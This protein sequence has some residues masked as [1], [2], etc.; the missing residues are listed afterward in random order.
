MKMTAV[1]AG[2]TPQTRPMPASP[3]TA[4]RLFSLDWLRI[5]LTILV[6]VH[7]IGQAYGPTGGY[8]PVQEPTRAAILGP[9]F[10]VNRSFF[11]SLFFLISGYF[12]VGAYQRNGF[13][14][15]LRNRAVRLGVP[16][17]VFAVLMIPARI[18]LFGEH[19]TRW[20]NWLNAGHLWYLEH[21][22]L[23][24]VVYA[25]WQKIRAARG[26]VPPG[27]DTRRPA[28]G[29]LVTLPVLVL[30]AAACGIV[31]IWSP[32]DRWMNLLGF[33]SVAF[34]DVPRDLAF[35]IFGA[36]AFR[37]GWLESF[38]ARRG[39]IW[40]GIGLA[41]AAAWY[42]WS[43]IPHAHLSPMAS[44]LVYVIWEELVCF[45]MCIGLLVLFRQAA[46]VQG[47]FGRTL[48]ANQY[49]AYFWHPILIVGI[50]MA[51]APLPLGPLVK[52]MAVTVIG[53]PVVFLWSWLLRRARAVRAVL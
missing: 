39:M 7:H 31:R 42:A 17:L 27:Q 28:P 37:R 24:S 38:P 2:V 50:Q 23:F 36:M 9:F 3:L 10:T 16:V 25:L 6:I 20:D 51:F 26:A 5:V 12:M 35:F 13:A 22:L 8:W 33:L 11:M 15:F 40:L 45:G 1:F 14:G 41:A 29:I 4:N 44:G 32:I 21:V 34:A 19:I 30:I 47:P 52:F 46:N 43:L 48:A 49:S 18:F 53:V